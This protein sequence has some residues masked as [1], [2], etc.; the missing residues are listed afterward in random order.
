M[1]NNESRYRRAVEE[2]QNEP[3]PTNSKA[4]TFD[5]VIGRRLRPRR[6]Q[7]WAIGTACAAIACVLLWPQPKAM[8]WSQVVQSTLGNERLHRVT[9]SRM[10]RGDT[11]TKT[12]EEWFDGE[13]SALQFSA[14]MAR[15]LSKAVFDVRSDGKR[16]YRHFPGS[17]AV[18][19]EKPGRFSF[20]GSTRKYTISGLL[21][22]TRIKLDKTPTEATL[23]GVPLLRYSAKAVEGSARAGIVFPMAFYAEKDRDR[24][25]RTEMFEPDGKLAE[26][27]IVDYPTLMPKDVFLPPADGARCYDLDKDSALVTKS[28]EHGVPF[29]NGNVL[30][31]ALMSPDGDLQILWTGAPPN[32]DGSQRPEVIGN[33]TRSVFAPDGLT[34]SRWKEN[35]KLIYRHEGA[36]LGGLALQL[37]KAIG[38]TVTLR[39]PV[40]V[41]DPNA[42]IRNSRGEIKG[43]RSKQ[44]GT[45]VIKDYPVIQ[46]LPFQALDYLRSPR[47]RKVF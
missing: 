28:M 37:K 16:V 45:T 2:L 46:T 44:V 3:I 17:Y 15:G 9:Y 25:V 14:T 7:Y 38:S 4:K 13:K 23:D 34:T 5:A 36:P 27:S 26:Y 32:G 20:P 12:G 33:P 18:I 47:G 24:V 30:R 39:M 21:S 31:A 11:W 22:D 42:P 1:N 43:Y 29:G 6:A 8:A 40:L 35:P 10:Y 19:Y 41:E